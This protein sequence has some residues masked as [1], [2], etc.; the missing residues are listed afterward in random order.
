MRWRLPLGRLKKATALSLEVSL[1]KTRFAN[2]WNF[3]VYPPGTNPPPAGVTVVSTLDAPVEP[4]L[5]AGGRVVVLADPA[6]IQQ[7]VGRYD[8]IFWNK[9]WFPSQVQH[10]L[11]LLLDPST[12]LSP[13]FRLPSSNWQ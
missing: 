13:V 2:D 7:R 6:T 3:W 4:V 5:A 11:G 1:P 10:T 12:R 9:M 8:P